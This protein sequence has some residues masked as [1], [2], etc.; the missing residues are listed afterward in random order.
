[1]EIKIELKIHL[2][3]K[4]KSL[5]NNKKKLEKIGVKYSCI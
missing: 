5:K 3:K 2:V 1:M 4:N